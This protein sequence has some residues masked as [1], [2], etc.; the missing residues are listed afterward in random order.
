MNDSTPGWRKRFA[1]CEKRARRSTS[2]WTILS[3]KNWRHAP[4]WSVAFSG[5]ELVTNPPPLSRREAVQRDEPIR[6]RILKIANETGANVIDP[7]AWLCD[8]TC[9]AVTADGSPNYKDYDHL[10][11]DA[12]VHVRYLDV[13]VMPRGLDDAARR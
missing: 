6:S 2:Y 4:W 10:S 1:R 12:L 9:P 8:E 13:L 7:M 5:I 11:L 3:A